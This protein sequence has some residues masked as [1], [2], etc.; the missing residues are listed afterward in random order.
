MSS[1]TQVQAFRRLLADAA[2]GG[3]AKVDALVA[4]SQR[5]VF[6]SVW[7]EGGDQYRTLLNSNG[8]SALPIFT[9]P[10]ELEEAATRFGWRAANGTAPLREVG[11]R[12]AM[13]H[14]LGHNLD[15]VVVD[16]AAAHALEAQVSELEPLLARSGSRDATGPFAVA[17]RLG[18][19]MMKAVKPGSG[20]YP[21]LSAVEGTRTRPPSVP[22]PAMPLVGDQSGSRNKLE[23]V[24][25]PSDDSARRPPPGVSATG[26]KPP[27][28]ITAHAGDG[29]PSAAGATFGSGSSV[30]LHPL[31]EPP[32]DELIN[33]LTEVL[34]GYPEVEWA[35][36]ARISRGPTEPRPAV[37]LRIDSGFRQRVNDIIQQLKVAADGAGAL[38]DVLLLDDPKVMRESR[39]VGLAFFPWRR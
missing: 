7:A 27:A 36:L 5:T 12:E 39:N 24:S 15:F 8:Q 37:C 21:A 26:A 14:A 17:G 20:S 2:Q 9:T 22:S 29:P 23:P 13:R 35:A 3:Q 25:R 31:Q 1:D 18:S 4:L 32:S 6:V 28:G 19:S 10:K 33:A 16:I 11:A 38:L 34:R 30:T